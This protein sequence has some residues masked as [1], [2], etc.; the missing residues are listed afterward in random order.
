MLFHKAMLTIGI[1]ATDATRSSDEIKR[2][3]RESVLLER[4]REQLDG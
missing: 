1:G 4:Y 2:A 3:S